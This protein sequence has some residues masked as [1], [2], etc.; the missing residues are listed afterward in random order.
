[1]PYYV[2]V[3]DTPE[4]QRVRE[5]QKNFS[6]VSPEKKLKTPYF[7]HFWR[8]LW[9]NLYSIELRFPIFSF[10]SFSISQTYRTVKEKSQWFRTPQKSWGW[11]KTR[12]ISARY[13]HLSSLLSPK[14][15]SLKSLIKLQFFGASPTGTVNLAGLYK[16]FF[17][18]VFVGWLPSFT[19]T[20]VTELDNPSL[21][22]YNYCP[23]PLCCSHASPS[24][25]CCPSCSVCLSC[26]PVPVA[27]KSPVAFCLQHHLQS[28]KWKIF[29]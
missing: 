11:R 17:P 20:A 10:H 24:L 26:C 9:G 8:K 16:V 27:I 18:D 13:G 19:G 15:Y 6:M 28:T 7:S 1:M 2:P 25:S 23:F 22:E 21:N 29:V 5:N 3:A 12:R 4:M 14:K